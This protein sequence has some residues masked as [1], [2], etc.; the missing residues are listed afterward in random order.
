QRMRGHEETT[1]LAS[2]SVQRI[3]APQRVLRQL[4]LAGPADRRPAA[5]PAH[6]CLGKKAQREAPPGSSEV[7]PLR[8]GFTSL[9]SR[10]REK[11]S[12]RRALT[13]ERAT[14]VEPA[15]SS[16][17]SWH[18]TTELRPRRAHCIAQ[19][20]RPG[21]AAGLTMHLFRG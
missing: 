3:T 17:G 7:Q 1:G 6:S 13:R 20:L 11:D 21:N 14:G 12:L 9:V 5:A 2:G 4:H 16:L 19:A 8:L 10:Q 15:T 18:S